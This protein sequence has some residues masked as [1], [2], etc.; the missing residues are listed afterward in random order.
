M[1]LEL[2]YLW[3]WFQELH[4]ARGGNG[5]GPNPFSYSDIAAWAGLTGTDIR[6]SEVK[7]ILILD[8]LWLVAQAESR[9]DHQAW[10][11]QQSQRRQSHGR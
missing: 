7:T 11:E 4:I 9:K 1:P 3:D 5:W 2:S 8:R 6:A 10:R